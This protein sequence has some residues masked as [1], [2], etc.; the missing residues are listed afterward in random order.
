MAK[1]HNSRGEER[2]ISQR[3]ARVER[4][5]KA[6]TKEGPPRPEDVVARQAMR[7]ERPNYLRVTRGNADYAGPVGRDIERMKG[8]S[9]SET[10][11]D[12]ERGA[13]SPIPARRRK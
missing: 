2:S 4:E 6:M 12:H 5:V 10:V 11:S 7:G 1:H 3:L 13:S 8:R 9:S